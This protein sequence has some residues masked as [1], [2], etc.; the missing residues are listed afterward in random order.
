MKVFTYSE[1]RQN[2]AKLLTL[3]QDTDVE[4]RRKDG[5]IFTLQ[6]KKQT[7]ASPFDVPGIEAQ[8]STA[9]IIQAV[10]DV[11]ARAG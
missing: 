8:A 10:Q 6:A 4:I 11:R 9:D 2:L 5:S 1:A 7:K 3:A